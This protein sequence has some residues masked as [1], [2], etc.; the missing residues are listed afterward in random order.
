MSKW[1]IKSIAAILAHAEEKPLHRSL[2]AVDLILL[3]IGCVIGTGIF[4]LT[5]VAAAKYAGPALVL[6]FILAGSASIFAALAYA[7]LAALVPVAGSAYTYTYAVLGEAAA[8]LVGWN[9]ILEYGVSG[10]AVASGWSGYV[11]G[12]LKS[13]NIHMPDALTKV[14]SSGGIIDLPAALICLVVTALLVRGVRES[15]RVNLVLVFAKMVAIAT[16]LFFAVPHIN[17]DL[18]HPFMP[19]GFFG[20][21]VMDPEKAGHMMQVGVSAGAGIIFFAYLGFDTV[22]TAAEETKNPNRDLPIGIIGSLLI[23]TILYIIV[24]GTLTGVTHY[25]ELNTKEPLAYVLRKLGYSFGG[26]LVAG[27]AIAGLST[28]MLTLLYG[29]TRIFFVMS[30]DGLLPR[31]VCDVHPKF[32]TPF[33]ITII[34][35][36]CTALVAGFLPINVIAELSNIGTLFA[37]IVV[38]VGVMIL[39][40][41]QP[42][43]HRPFRCPA[44][45]LVAPLAVVGCLYLIYSLPHETIVRFFIWSAIGMV[46]YAFY[47]YSRSPLHPKNSP[48]PISE[49]L[50][51]ALE[52]NAKPAE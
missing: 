40:V 50:Q 41:K 2:T 4:V 46:I 49:M 15:A 14:P 42:D 31:S 17:P 34:T 36:V 11:V 26:A 6:S 52:A 25:S 51:P 3:G 45:W 13:M 19:Y 27:G 47:G 21:E 5:G 16:F 24:S 30:R 39:R 22:A 7:E 20:H 8:W 48:T 37:F 10:G 43:L 28:V 35:G 18:W 32:G 33:K 29:Q 9:L 12:A 23:C 38:S 44:V 1:R